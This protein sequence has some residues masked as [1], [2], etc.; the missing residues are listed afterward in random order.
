MPTNLQP[1]FCQLG[2]VVEDLE[3]AVAD[4]TARLKVG[5][6][7]IIRSITLP[8]TFRGQPSEPLIDIAL[9]YV[10]EMQ[11]ELIQQRNT[12]PS[13]YR[14]WIDAKRFGLHHAAVFSKDV[15]A[16]V[17]RLQASG[18]RLACDIRAPAGRYVYFDSPVV[19]EQ[20]YLEL[21]EGSPMM[22]GMFQ[23]GIAAAAAWDGRTP[24]TVIDYAQMR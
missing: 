14:A 10:G 21:L 2:H 16:D 6:W 17:S 3:R 24:P 22:L 15:E 9:G 12:A 19:G 5:P 4:W 8:C 23:Q 1:P 7:T 11:I 18:M 13:P 20:S